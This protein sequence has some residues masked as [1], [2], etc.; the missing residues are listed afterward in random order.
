MTDTHIKMPD[1]APLARYL[2]D[3]T[4]TNFV[5]PFPIF[6]DADLSVTFDGAPQYSGYTVAG[7]GLTGGGS[8]TF[9]TAPADG[10]I[11]VLERVLPLQRVTD[12]LEG[13][14]FSAQGIN[15]ELNYLTG[16]IQQVSR[17]LS[18][19]LRYSDAETPANVELP[20]KTARAN[21]ALGFDGDGNPIAVSL[22]GSMA[23]P[24]FTAQGTGAV[25]RTTTD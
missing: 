20:A 3:G 22:A 23:P 4:L 5:Y 19:M 16:E 25:S 12:F 13:G 21:K 9:A 24:S 14:D 10:V 7:A 11:V 8:V 1:V 17:A 18:P 6:E 15:N 2:A